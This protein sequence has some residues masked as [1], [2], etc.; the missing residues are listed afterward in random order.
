MSILRLF[1]TY[2]V[3]HT[4]MPNFALHLLS[5]RVKDAD[6]AEL[7][8]SSLK[9]AVLGAEPVRPP[10]VRAF[11]ARLERGKLKFFKGKEREREEKGR[12]RKEERE[13][14]FPLHFPL[15]DANWIHENKFAS[16]IH[17]PSV[18]QGMRGVASDGARS[19]QR[20]ASPSTCWRWQG[21]KMT[22]TTFP[23]A[24]TSALRPL[25]RAAM[26]QCLPTHPEPWKSARRAHR[27][28]ASASASW[29]R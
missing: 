20:L 24:F 7:D 29:I 17:P 11:H 1:S 28:L 9:C 19:C 18:G 8:L 14:P 27:G 15:A 5:T 2:K 13:K 21:G 25:A 12:E 6:I 26:S 4:A 22:R 16:S 23:L 3:T 10:T